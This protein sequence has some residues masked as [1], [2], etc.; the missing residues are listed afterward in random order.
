[1]TAA[2][3]RLPLM[4][5]ASVSLVCTFAV[6][7][8]LGWSLDTA[9]TEV[10]ISAPV[11]AKTDGE[12]SPG[13]AVVLPQVSPD[14]VAQPIYNGQSGIQPIAANDPSSLPAQ[15]YPANVPLGPPL[16][17]G[18]AGAAGGDDDS[19]GPAPSPAPTTAPPSSP[20]S[21]PSPTPGDDETTPPADDSGEDDIPETEDDGVLT[22]DDLVDPG[23]P[24]SESGGST[25]KVSESAVTE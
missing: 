14:S 25:E 22:Y 1:M 2:P 16:P 4:A 11:K 3:H 6:G 8:S 24:G 18:T 5:F 17:P 12:R 21:D 13:G 23:A 10:A 19:T 20:P 7:N 9:N 15:T